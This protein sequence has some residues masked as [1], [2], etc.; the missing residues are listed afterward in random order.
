MILTMT[1]KTPCRIER[2]NGQCSPLSRILLYADRTSSSAPV[3][4]QLKEKGFFI[5][6]IVWK[7]RQTEHPYNIIEFDAGFNE[8]RDGTGFKYNVRGLY[9]FVNGS[10]TTTI[11]QVPKEGRP[12]FFDLLEQTARKVLLELSDEGDTTPQE[13]PQ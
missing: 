2:Q 5:T 10:H 12:P 13:T 6:N 9:W 4:E 11:R 1:M 8:P 3:Y 7:S